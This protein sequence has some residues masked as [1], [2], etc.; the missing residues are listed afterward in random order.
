MCG[1][2]A[3]FGSSGIFQTSAHAAESDFYRNKTLTLVVGSAVS[4]GYDVYARLS[5]AIS[6]ARSVVTLF[7]FFR[8]I[9]SMFDPAKTNVD[10]RGLNWLGSMSEDLSVC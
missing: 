2:L 4:G 5:R 6:P 8:I 9:N 10:I 7:D 3:L 1:L